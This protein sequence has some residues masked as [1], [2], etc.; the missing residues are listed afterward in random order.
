M[1]DKE[2]Q[3]QYCNDIYNQN[4]IDRWTK[5]CILPFLKKGD[6]RIAKN[7]QGITLTSIV[8]K[9]YNVLLCNQIKPKIEKILRMNQNGLQRN[10]L[11]SQILTIRWILGVHAKNLKVTL[12]LEDFSKALDSIHWGKM[13][14]ILLADRLPKETVIAIMMLY[15]NMKVRVHSLDGDA[16]FFDIVADVLQ[17]DA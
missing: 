12:L 14:Q 2:I 6:L 4:T 15:K 8:A 9:I 13:E 1:E 16:D 11:T 7:Y 5:G 3:F 10:R 17:G